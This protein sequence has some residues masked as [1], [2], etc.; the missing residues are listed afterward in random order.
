L[1]IEQREKHKSAEQAFAGKFVS[2]VSIHDQ[3]Y[4][5]IPNLTNKLFRL[6]ST[7]I[8]RTLRRFVAEIQ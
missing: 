2:S 3:A 7:R 6:F 1:K 8:W 4:F 5:I